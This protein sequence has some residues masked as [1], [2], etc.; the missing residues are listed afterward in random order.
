MELLQYYTNEKWYSPHYQKPGVF[1][2][3][4][5][6]ILV[7]RRNDDFCLWYDLFYHMAGEEDLNVSFGGGV[8]ATDLARSDANEVIKLNSQ[9][10]KVSS[11]VIKALIQFQILLKGRHFYRVENW[12]DILK[13]N[14]AT[15]NCTFESLRKE[16]LSKA[17]LPS[18]ELHNIHSTLF[19]D[20]PSFF[21]PLFVAVL[22]NDLPFLEALI[23]KGADPILQPL[24]PEGHYGLL[25]QAAR[26]GHHSLIHVLVEAGCPVNGHPNEMSRTP[27]AIAAH[28]GN[29]MFIKTLA[30][31]PGFDL[32]S[33]QGAH[34]MLAAAQEGQFHVIPTLVKL[35]CKV[36]ECPRGILFTPLHLAARGDHITVVETLLK[37]GADPF[38][39]SSRGETALH[40]AAEH[41]SFQVIQTLLKSGL[42][43]YES[44]KMVGY[45][46]LNPFH[47]AFLY[48]ALNVLKAFTSANCPI[49]NSLLHFAIW[50]RYSA[51]SNP[52]VPLALSRRISI[53]FI[54][55][56][57]K[58]GC[59]VTAS[60]HP[61]QA[62]SLPI[63]YA[64]HC[65]D[66]A[67][68]QL[69]INFGCPKNAFTRS[70]DGHR[71]TPMQVA[72]ANNSVEAIRVLEANGCNVDFHHPLED[73]PLHVAIS[74]ESVEAVR[75]LLELGASVTLRN[76]DELP[77]MHTAIV[78]N[79]IEVI[80]LLYQHGASV[81]DVPPDE[82]V[83]H[84]TD[85]QAQQNWDLLGVLYKYGVRAVDDSEVSSSAQKAAHALFKHMV[86]CNCGNSVMSPLACAVHFRN[87]AAARKLIDLGANINAFSKLPRMNPLVLACILGFSDMVGDLIDFGADYR[88]VDASDF[89][90]IHTAIKYNQP[91]VVQTLINK[92]CDP[93]VPTIVRGKP[94]LT[95]FQL[96][97]IMRC[98]EILQILHKF[99]PDIHRLTPDHLSPLHLASVVPGV[100]FPAPYGSVAIH[101]LKIKAA[102]QEETVK[103]L[104]KYGCDVNA[105]ALDLT[106]LD[107]AIHYKLE[108]VVY[109]LT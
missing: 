50:V 11:P 76:Q 64:S 21:T 99:V 108:K 38:R 6:H 97:C 8:T 92:G 51:K 5:L 3:H 15:M 107:F 18:L 89:L 88:E 37:H 58:L 48:G 55:E 2:V 73:P 1:G 109:L 82:Q 96:A 71:L 60:D 34:A 90:P 27:L 43:P 23:S 28:Y 103:L 9:W 74:S 17:L 100:G 41:D 19:S 85:C 81:T 62:G 24:A 72:A 52:S 98:P 49:P 65:N 101:P 93:N 63:H 78:C 16:G 26:L 84:L 10:F 12:K 14:Y 22:A 61:F 46:L 86:L 79:Q 83:Q 31:S 7:Y 106:P 32:Q 29:L 35:G 59:S 42:S 53:H 47:V 66:P 40:L 13:E 94:D 70:K 56:V 4:P 102:R 68:I 57:V 33:S 75:A 30:K 77:P 80:E 20:A 45:Q 91:S 69:L 39:V 104:L 87:R 67:V 105:T 44:K 25:H 95:P 36:D 54:A